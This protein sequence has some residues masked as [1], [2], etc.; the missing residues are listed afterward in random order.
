MPSAYHGFLIKLIG[1]IE[2]LRRCHAPGRGKIAV[3][4]QAT[5][6][7]CPVSRIWPDEPALGIWTWLHLIQLYV[8]CRGGGHRQCRLRVIFL[9][10]F[11]CE[12]LL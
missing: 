3:G 7:D 4:I 11:E 10:F 1:Q 2:Q 5:N 6:P 12:R 9:A 8:F